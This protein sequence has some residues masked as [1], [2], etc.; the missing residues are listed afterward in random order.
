MPTLPADRLASAYLYY[1]AQADDARLCLTVARTAAA[2]GAVVANG[3]AVVGLDKDGEARRRASRVEAD[4]DGAS[5]CAAASWST[6]PAC[7]PTTCARSTR[8]RTRTPSGPAKGIHLTVPWDKVRNDIAVVIPVPKDRRWLFV[9]PWGDLTYVGTTDT[10]YDG[11]ARRPAVH[12]RRHR[13]RARRAQRLG[14]D[15]RRPRPTWSAPGPAC[16][17]SCKRRRAG[18]TADLSRRHQVAAS[19]QR[20][21]HRHRRQAHDLPADGGRRRRRAS[22]TALG[23]P[24]A[25]RRTTKRLRLLGRRRATTEPAG[26]RPPTRPTSLRRYGGRAPRVLDGDGRRRPRPGRAARARPALPRGPRRC[27]P[28]ATRWPAPSTTCCPAAPGPACSPATPPADRGRGVGRL[29]A[30][31]LGW[32]DAEI[33]APGRGLP[34]LGRARARRPAAT[35]A[36]G[37]RRGARRLSDDRPTP[38]DRARRPGRGRAIRA[39]RSRRPLDA[40]VRDGAAPP[41]ARTRRSRAGGDRAEASRDWWPLAMDW[42]LAGQVAALAAGRVP[43]RPTSDEVAA[44]ARAVPRAGVPVTAAGGRSGVCGASVPVHGG[45]RARPHRPGRHRRRRRRRL[46]VDVLPG[47]F[48]DD[49]ED[50]LRAAHGLTLGHWPQS[51]DAV[52]RR[53]LAGVPGRRPVLDPL[54]QD[55]GHGR[56]PRGRAGRR[57]R[58]SHRRLAPGRRRARPHPA[59]RRLARARSA[60]SPGPG[61]ACIPCPPAERRAAFGFAAFDDGLDACRRILRRGA[62]PAVLRLYDAAESAAQL[63]H[64]RP[65][66]VLLVLDEGDAGDRRRHAGRRGRASAPAAQRARR[67]RWSSAGSATA[68]TSSALEALTRKGFVVDTMEV[69]GAVGR[70][71]AR[72]TSA[73]AALAR[74]R[75]HP[76]GLAPTSRTATPTAPA[77]TSPSPATPA[78]PTR[79]RRPTSRCGTPA[80]APCSPPAAPSATTTASAS[81]APASWPRRSAPALDVLAAVKAALDP[82]GILNPGKLGLAAAR[83][84]RCAWP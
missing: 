41:P 24:R 4:G 54:R 62:T 55:R 20:R 23:P 27:T 33:G 17:R 3:A 84:A 61:C 47:T 43:A 80:P 67:R 82:A 1:D 31:E 48:G 79:S 81:T 7:G 39:W 30:P 60:S 65:V 28:S 21:R 5:T 58:S 40:A 49:L 25:R 76:G 14:H 18:R 11:A 36:T 16:A 46:V 19:P 51:I 72:S 32:D 63:R 78:A 42:A 74:R 13:L 9:V 22:W 35:P 70:P 50:D 56:R 75:A 64:R 68:T 53:R 52:D 8:A 34:R 45:V 2:H 15:R 38:P 12:A 44:R 10:D 83:S 59:L 66:A 69:A 37:A 29:I 73:V 71:A 57:H 6:P 77:S 26:R